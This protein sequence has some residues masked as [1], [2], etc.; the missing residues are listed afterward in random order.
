M[1]LIRE[2]RKCRRVS[3]DLNKKMVHTLSKDVIMGSARLLGIAGQGD[4]ILFDFEEEVNV[5]MDFAL[6]DYMINDRNA[7]ENYQEKIGGQNELEKGILNALLSSYTSLF[8]V[9]SI[10]ERERVLV[11][12]DLLNNVDNIK[13]TDIALSRSAVPG[14]LLF[15]RLVPFEHEFHRSSGIAFVFPGDLKSQ[16]LR[17]Y[18]ILSKRIKSENESIKRFASF[19]K[20]NR[21]FGIKVVYE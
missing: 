8:E 21:T 10:S 6:N 12:K 16:L 18:K 14:L 9:I 15:I 1:S 13:L 20:L 3:K 5:L 19:L 2:Y 7:V 11:L 4:S 17:R